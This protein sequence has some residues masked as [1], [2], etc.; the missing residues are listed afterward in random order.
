MTVVSDFWDRLALT[1]QTPKTTKALRHHGE[2]T[3]HNRVAFPLLLRRMSC[4]RSG[5]SS[6]TVIGRRRLLSSFQKEVL[7]RARGVEADAVAFVLSMDLQKELVQSCRPT[8]AICRVGARKPYSDNRPDPTTAN[9]GSRTRRIAHNRPSL[10]RGSN[11]LVG[12]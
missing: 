5:G 10:Q 4:A 11:H 6:L 8:P 9:G 12:G 3:C 1:S 7:G 2:Q